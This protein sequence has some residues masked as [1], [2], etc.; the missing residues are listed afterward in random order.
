MDEIRQFPLEKK[1]LTTLT[2]FYYLQKH[3]IA[4]QGFTSFGW[5][6]LIGKLTNKYKYYGVPFINSLTCLSQLFG[7]YAMVI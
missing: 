4:F 1:T 5:Q 7:L 2:F 6:L 3:Y